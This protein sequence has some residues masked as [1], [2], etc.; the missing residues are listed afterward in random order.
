MANPLGVGFEVKKFFFDSALVM[1][2]TTK[3]DRK[4]LS[5][6]GAFV[7]R[8]ARSSI[9]PGGKKNKS[10]EPGEPPRSHTGFLKKN[11]FFAYE[12]QAKNVVIGPIVISSAGGADALDAL[13]HG[14]TTTIERLNKGKRVK[15]RKKIE[16]RPFMTPAFEKEKSSI[17]KIWSS[18]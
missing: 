14:G 11:I 17:S 2:E 3:E 15:E 6:F 4:R 18:V 8:T 13:E 10:S 12:P 1:K 16:A 9:R 7:R 5:K